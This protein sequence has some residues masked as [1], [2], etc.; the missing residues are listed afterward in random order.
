MSVSVSGVATPAS[1]T[2][3]QSLPPTGVSVIGTTLYIVGGST[4]SDTA[5]VKPA[6]VR[7][8]G[9]TGLT[10]SATL[11]RVS[12]SKSFTQP[13]TAIIIAGYAGNETFTLAPTLTLPTTVTAGNGNDVLQLGGGDSIVVLGDGNDTVSA[14]DG[15]DTVTVG[16]GNDVIQLGGGNN[17]VT[18]GNGNDTIH[19]GDGSN[20]VVEGDGN[21]TVSAGNGDNLI[22][23]GLGQHTI[24]VGNGTNILID[25]SATVNQS[26]DSFRRILDDWVAN[27]TA[28]NQG[29]IRQRFTVNYNAKYANT[30]TAGSGIDWFFYQNPPTT[31]NKKSTDFWTSS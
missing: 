25:G 14:G 2:L 13:F 27:P 15:N 8:D 19:Q 12:S 22:V 20:V 7:N 29:A 16:N 18:A 24:Q 1:F 5:A 10:V 3:T 30:L 31:S 17:T 28:S 23:G 9:S 6:G 11:N 4:S 26:G 21:D